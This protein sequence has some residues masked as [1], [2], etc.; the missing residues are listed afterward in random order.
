MHSLNQQQVSGDLPRIVIE[1]SYR[2]RAGGRL[3]FAPDKVCCVIPNNHRDRRIARNS[4]QQV[5][6]ARFAPTF[7]GL[8]DSAL[9]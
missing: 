1:I 7:E 9:G 3:S 4:G 6:N 2:L 8:G 5:I